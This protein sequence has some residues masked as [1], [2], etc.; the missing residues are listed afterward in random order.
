MGLGPAGAQVDLRH[1]GKDVLEVTGLKA[2]VLHHLQQ[3]IR[4]ALGQGFCCIQEDFIVDHMTETDSSGGVLAFHF[5]QV[6]LA[7]I[8]E[9]TEFSIP[10]LAGGS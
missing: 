2:G 4:R 5:S 6:E 8:P 9:V 1:Q 7:Q 3:Q 10:A